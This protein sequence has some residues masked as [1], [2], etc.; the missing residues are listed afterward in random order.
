M[1]C[2]EKVGK[3]SSRQGRA[4]Q[5]PERRTWPV[6]GIKEGYYGLVHS[7]REKVIQDESSKVVPVLLIL[8]F[9]GFSSVWED[10]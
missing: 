1:K 6:T 7:M 3:T 9:V 10:L 2:V 4:L 5:S 8:N